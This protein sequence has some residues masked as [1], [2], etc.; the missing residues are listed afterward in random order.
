MWRCVS[1]YTATPVCLFVLIEVTIVFCCSQESV[2]LASC[3]VTSTSQA[4]SVSPVMPTRRFLHNLLQQYQNCPILAMNIKTSQIFPQC[5]A[6]NWKCW[7]V[8]E[9]HKRQTATNFYLKGLLY[10][11]AKI[12]FKVLLIWNYPRLLLNW[13]ENSWK[14]NFYTTINFIQVLAIPTADDFIIYCKFVN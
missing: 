14:H 1:T 10:T 9:R 4:P 3:P 11:D 5:F 13:W 2:R 8:K 12:F 7:K 6:Q